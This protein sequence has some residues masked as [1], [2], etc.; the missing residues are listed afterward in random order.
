MLLTVEKVLF[1]KATDLFAGI[2]DEDLVAVAQIAVARG[3]PAQHPVFA[4]GDL[5]DSLYVVVRG[6]VRIHIGERQLVVLKERQ[7]FGELAVID[8][9]PRSASATALDDT[10]LLEIGRAP[11]MELLERSPE[12][13]R[14]VLLYLVSK[15][16]ALTP[17]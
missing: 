12:V 2:S 15:V 8:P 9:Q 4:A 10:L 7:H 6:Q 17:K 13:V 5:G 11:F 16:R 1:L 14:G 3:I